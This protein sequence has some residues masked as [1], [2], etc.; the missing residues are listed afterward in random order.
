M[1]SATA[2]AQVQEPRVSEGAE[3][4]WAAA[5]AGDLV[6]VA[7]ELDAGV[8]VNAATAYQTTALSF[9]SDRG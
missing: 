7:K 2:L 5:K 4:L 8:D 1:C 6:A 3:R 9:A